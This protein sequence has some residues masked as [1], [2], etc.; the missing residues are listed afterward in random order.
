MSRRV[1]LL[2]AGR[3]TGM[4]TDTVVCGKE[5]TMLLVTIW[6]SAHCWVIVDKHGAAH[7]IVGQLYQVDTLA[8]A[9]LYLADGLRQIGVG[10]FLGANFPMI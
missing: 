3:L 1:I 2:G 8:V 7:R 6:I 10:L 4:T 9:V 5:E